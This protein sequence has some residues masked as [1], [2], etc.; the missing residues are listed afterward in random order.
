LSYSQV[1]FLF[2]AL[3]DEITKMTKSCCC[4]DSPTGET[5]NAVNTRKAQGKSQPIFKPKSL[6]LLSQDWFLSKDGHPDY[7]ASSFQ[8]FK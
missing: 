6:G 3:K 5:V 8:K 2:K 7:A 1:N 4:L